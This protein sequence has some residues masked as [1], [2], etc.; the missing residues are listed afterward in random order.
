MIFRVWKQLVI[1]ESVDEIYYVINVW[2]FDT[3][4]WLGL[5]QRNVLFQYLLVYFYVGN[6]IFESWNDPV[7][8]LPMKNNLIL[9][10]I[11]ELIKEVKSISIELGLFPQ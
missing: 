5:Q 9:K 11:V 3:N 2:G 10:R 6:N 8:V 1:K 4:G 7:E